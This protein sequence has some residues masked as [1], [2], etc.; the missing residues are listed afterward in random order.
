MP[1][2]AALQPLTLTPR[3]AIAPSSTALAAP[4]L[5]PSPIAFTIALAAAARMPS[6]PRSPQASPA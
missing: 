5:P 1:S 4:S 3:A 6:E 2:R